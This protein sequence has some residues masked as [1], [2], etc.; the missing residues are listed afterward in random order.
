MKGLTLVEVLVA[1]GIS[2]IV[3][4]LLLVIM[5]NSA[6]LYLKQASKL[7]E[8]LN[9]ND[10]LFRVRDS[11]KQSSAIT[12]TFSIDSTTYTSG[13]TQLVLKVSSIDSSSNIIAD[14]FDHYVFFQD[15]NMLRFKT[16]P[17]AL[18]SRKPQD[19]IFSTS[20]DGLNFKYFNTATPPEEVSPPTASKVRISIT[21]KQI[22][23]TSEANLRND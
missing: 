17:S 6:G 16:F 4:G 23:A 15:N 1:M 12:A 13:A 22:T 2:I 11:I 14:T 5:V 9:I 18:S 20:L 7:T 3:G 10:A 8:G 19:Q 21:L